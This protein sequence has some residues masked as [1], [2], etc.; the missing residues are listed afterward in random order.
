M[1]LGIL[2]GISSFFVMPAA[3]VMVALAWTMW[4]ILVA[5]VTLATSVVAFIGGILVYKNHEAG[6]VLLGI[7]AVPC[8]FSALCGIAVA[9]FFAVRE[10]VLIGELFAGAIGIAFLSVG[11]WV[12]ICAV[13]LGLATWF[14]WL[15][16]RR[17]DV[18]AQREGTSS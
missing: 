18:E 11:I 8:V 10:G 5:V 1:V 14:A 4:L 17:V 16:W 3:W 6:F 13:L 9:L 7:G 2:G 12:V 15:A